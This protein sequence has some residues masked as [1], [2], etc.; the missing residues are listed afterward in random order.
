MCV[1]VLTLRDC[2][3]RGKI[4]KTL[5][6]LQVSLENLH[7]RRIID[8]KLKFQPFTTLTFSNPHNR[9]WVSR[10]VGVSWGWGRGLQREKTTGGK[11]NMSPY[12]HHPSVR[13][14]QQSTLSQNSNVNVMFSAKI[15]AVASWNRN[16]VHVGSHEYSKLVS[17]L[18]ELAILWRSTWTHSWL[19]PW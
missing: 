1:F 12:W 17:M 13:K 2:I 4:K 8:W 7:F 11:H 9:T 6:L 5:A 19:K 16:Y 15:F 18:S 3:P 10:P 14:T